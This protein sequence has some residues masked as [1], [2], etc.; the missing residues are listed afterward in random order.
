MK[1]VILTG[2]S[3]FIGQNTSAALAAE[4]YELHLLSRR[5]PA[6]GGAGIWHSCDLLDS[7][8]VEGIMDKIKPDSLLHLA[9]YAEHGKYWESPLNLDWLSATLNL[10][11]AF[12]ESGGKRLVC[13]GSAAEYDW[14]CSVCH[15]KNSPLVPSSL[16]GAAKH[17]LNITL[18]AFARNVKLSYAWARLFSVFG[19]GENLKRF[20]PAVTLA[21][22]K[23]QPP[24][25]PSPEL[26]RDFLYVKDMSA[27]L[28]ALLCSEVTGPVNIASGQPLMAKDL[29]ANIARLTGKADNTSY[30]SAPSPYPLVIAD[31]A[32]LRNEVGWQPAFSLEQALSETITYWKNH[33][34]N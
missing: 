20:V 5:Q 2:A 7:K 3:G 18:E 21:L 19:P 29:I 27:A 17:S 23:G 22:L 31:V 6:A 15:E 13:V 28:I 33:Q 1:K 30:G 12:A 26:K 24:V 16:Y 14:S 11:R 4:G 8:A 10:A 25:C 32:R 34:E 9:W